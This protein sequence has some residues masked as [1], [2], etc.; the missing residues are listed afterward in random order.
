M[1]WWCST[2]Q[3]VVAYSAWRRRPR[4][5]RRPKLVVEAHRDRLVQA[6][7]GRVRE[8]GA[9]GG[10]RVVDGVPVTGARR[11][12][13]PSATATAPG[14]VAT[15]PPGLEQDLAAMRW[16]AS[17]QLLRQL[18]ASHS[19]SGPAQAHRL[20]IDRQVDEGDKRSL[21]DQCPGRE[22]LT[23]LVGDHLS[24]MQCSTSGPRCLLRDVDVLQ[25]H[26]GLEDLTRV[27]KDEGACW[28]TPQAQERLR[29]FLAGPGTRLPAEN[30]DEPEF[31]GGGERNRT[32][33]QGFAGPCLS[34][35]PR[36]RGSLTLPLKL[37]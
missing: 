1:I 4:A 32:A 14:P 3:T 28:L 10:D 24:M 19:T 13:S 34:T 35:R 30:P 17:T 26:Q 37:E 31:V 18:R 16:S 25:A 7:S 27:G 12:L 36:R 21:L 15:S 2:S 6:L 11:P 9:I 5:L 23:S 29:H 22:Q 8:G 20:A 33:V